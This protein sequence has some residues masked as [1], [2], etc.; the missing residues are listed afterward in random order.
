M[1]CA[2]SSQGKPNWL[3]EIRLREGLGGWK[4]TS[5]KTYNAGLVSFDGYMGECEGKCVVLSLHID[6]APLKSFPH[7]TA[8]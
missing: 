6:K 7:C 3:L 5:F 2:S 8:Q 1:S 4:T